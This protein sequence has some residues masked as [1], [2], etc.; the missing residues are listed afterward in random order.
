[1]LFYVKDKAIEFV[2]IV[3]VVLGINAA[4]DELE[5]NDSGDTLKL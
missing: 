3:A 4:G 2:V 5:I 1:M